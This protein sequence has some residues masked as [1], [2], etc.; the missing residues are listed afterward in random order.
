MRSFALLV[1]LAATASGQEL[2]PER[3]EALAAATVLVKRANATLAGVIVRKQ[4]KQAVVLTGP[5]AADET[6]AYKPWI[7]VRL[8]HNT[9]KEHAV[10]ANVLMRFKD[11]TLLLVNSSQDDLAE[12]LVPAADPATDRRVFVCGFDTRGERPNMRGNPASIV[13]GTV[14][15]ATVASALAISVADPK[16]KKDLV[17][18]F[19]GA[20]V[21]D[22][23][24]GL[25]GIGASLV[26]EV[27]GDGQTLSI[28][29]HGLALAELPQDRPL[30]PVLE[31][32]ENVSGRIR[33][34][35]KAALVDPFSHL[36]EVRVAWRKGPGGAEAIE[37]L[38]RVTIW[39]SD[40]GKGEVRVEGKAGDE[41]ELA[42]RVLCTRDGAE[43]ASPPTLLKVKF[44]AAKAEDDWLGKEGPKQEP[45]PG[46]AP[47]ETG[48]DLATPPTTVLDLKVTKL[49][50]SGKAVIP[51]ALW[52]GDSRSLYLLE[53]AG[54]LHK[55]E[56]ASLREERVLEVGKPA[57]WLG[58][59]K[60]GLLVSVPDLQELWVLD[61]ETL[62]RKAAIPIGK[63]DGFLAS[64]GIAYA[65]AVT[66]DAVL[67]LDLKRGAALKE[68]KQ[69]LPS[70][71][72]LTPDGKFLITADDGHLS[73]LR[74]E[75]A[76]FFRDDDADKAFRPL[77][78]VLSPDAKEV[79]LVS[80][81]MVSIFE[82]GDLKKPPTVL[83]PSGNLSRFGFGRDGRFLAQIG[84]CPLVSLSAAGF[85]E[86][87]YALGQLWGWGQ[88]L[89]SPDGRRLLVHNGT[90][91][92]LTDLPN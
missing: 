28:G 15:K 63:R 24:C 85:K 9:G 86:K 16:T 6:P 82:L 18:V 31:E 35:L 36:R 60:E 34:T 66:P 4:G 73:R 74:V 32:V 45:A 65:F 7:D 30:A 90:E 25:V 62:A 47:R 48:R 77:E 69:R 43:V 19:V 29:P 51:G 46:P 87:E 14:Q 1:A 89:P 71:A 80:P 13:P 2:T 78:L 44:A 56:A 8:R 61:R 57:A 12:P 49:A 26:R 59:S 21:V 17:G 72:A 42:A 37:A 3:G 10:S 70:A 76:Q 84:A 41:V 20:P 52:S 58:D 81:T 27:W 39:P 11:A 50:L 64:P 23:N 91:L 53:K 75:G 40:E 38:E 54:T 79:A 83:K 22:E 5:L 92:F 55:I 33:L 68:T 88:L 67:A